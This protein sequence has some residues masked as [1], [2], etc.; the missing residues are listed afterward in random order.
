[1][2][3]QTLLGQ[4]LGPDTRAA[5]GD[6][7]QS[8]TTAL[9]NPSAK[10][11]LGGVAAG[12]LL[13]LLVGSKKARKTAGKLAGGVVGYGGAAAL[14]ALA[15]RA[16]QKWQDQKAQ[17]APAGTGHAAQH[18]AASRAPATIAP[19]PPIAGRFDPETIVGADGRPFAL[20]LVR[21]MIAA[22]NADGHID[23]EERKTILSHLGSLQ[24]GVEERAFVFEALMNPSSVGEIA[25]LA[26]G[27]EQATEI[28]LVSRMAID[29][30]DPA[31]RKYLD[32]LARHLA[33]PA[34]LVTELE[35]QAIAQDPLAA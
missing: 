1:M 27:A 2:N 33:L 11:A 20:T 6:K 15:H 9:S 31:E 3:P 24:L 14:G 10:V 8:A 22:A 29:P 21:A 23:A 12:G 17:A 30:D 32:D 28:Y 18:P 13:G 16:Y 19:T 7:L 26:N 4:F 5:A 34:D 35:T 25:D